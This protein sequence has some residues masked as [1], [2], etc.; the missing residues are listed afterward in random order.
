MKTLH[1]DV[2]PRQVQE[3]LAAFPK[4]QTQ[5]GAFNKCKLV[6]LELSTYL[7]QR[8]YKARL[9]HVAGLIG[10]FAEPHPEWADKPPKEWSHYLVK[11]GHRF[12]DPTIRQFDDTA[13]L[14][15]VYTLWELR[16][17]WSTV[18]IDKFMNQWVQETLQIKSYRV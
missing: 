13:D 7:R 2:L 6:S 11:V 10:T 15:A 14:P 5:R 8:G 18:E 12:F 17:M 3:F 4:L 16:A 9:V 1:P